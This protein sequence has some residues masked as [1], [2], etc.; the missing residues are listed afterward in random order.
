MKTILFLLIPL[1][2][3]SQ[4]NLPTVPQPT[5]MPNYSNQNYSNP[6][7]RS[8][9]PNTSSQYFNADKQRQQKQTEQIMREVEQ[10][11]KLQAETLKQIKQDIQEFTDNKN[12]D[13]NFK[14]LSN[15]QVAV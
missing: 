8:V 5:Q 12:I 11:E 14:S 1:F 6:N 9:V 4:V 15:K 10:N 2:T 3:F 13:Y 7:N